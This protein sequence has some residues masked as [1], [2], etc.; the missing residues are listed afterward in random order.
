MNPVLKPWE[1]H[2]SP[3]FVWPHGKLDR[4]KWVS[5]EVA[6]DAGLLP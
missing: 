5:M 3:V 1:S 4:E 6:S 2:C